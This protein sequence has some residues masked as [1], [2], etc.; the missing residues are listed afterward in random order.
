MAVK[1]V[2]PA[3]GKIIQVYAE[4]D[5]TTVSDIIASTH[6]AFLPWRNTHFKQRA[7]ILQKAAEILAKNKPA[8]A[9]LMT[10]EMGKPI[11]FSIAEIEK[12][13]RACQY[14]AENAEKLLAP[15]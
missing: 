15:Q 6:A 10:Q 1:T 9:E 8:Y 7:Q 2:N 11:R 13:A 12:C 4:M 14:F 3:T 5:M